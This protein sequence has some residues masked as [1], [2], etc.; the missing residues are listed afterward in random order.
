MKAVV[1]RE[2]GGPE[3]LR[4]EDVPEPSAG[5]GEIKVKVGAVS[6]NRTLDLIVRSGEYVVKPKLPHVLG[7]DPA[8]TVVD[9]GEG[10]EHPRVG[11][12]VALQGTVR[13]GRC[14]QCLSGSSAAC[15]NT[16]HLGVHRWGGYAEYVVVPAANGFV[17]PEELSF[18]EASIIARHFPTAMNLLENKAQLK[19]DEWV[20]I[21]G[22][23]GAL[24]SCLVQLARHVG[25]RVI[26]AAGSDERVQA[27]LDN[28]AEFGV[29]YRKQ[30]LAAEV[31]RITGGRGVNVVAENIADPTLWP[32]AFD[33]LAFEGRLVTAG[34]HGGGT[35]PLDVKRLYLQRLTIMGSP[36]SNYRDVARALEIAGRGGIKAFVGRILPLC[37]AAEAHRLVERNAVIGKVMLEP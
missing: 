28:G 37:D 3:V 34:A 10:V 12:R 32:G 31:R 15:P 27:C 20:L 14:E 2:F 16:Q 4:C 21:M 7:V 23:A 11:D 33:S 13:C 30:D 25:A 6:V 22:A 17:M 24:G 29:N 19:A 26:A 36:G 35:V 18:A 8:G 9:V 1:M 5:P